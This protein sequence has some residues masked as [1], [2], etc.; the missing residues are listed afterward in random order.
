[1]DKI[2]NENMS[3]LEAL[4]VCYEEDKKCKTEAEKEAL[5]AEY[6]K[7]DNLIYERDVKLFEAGCRM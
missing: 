6:E 3:E 5:F 7:I 2:F 4:S 1:M